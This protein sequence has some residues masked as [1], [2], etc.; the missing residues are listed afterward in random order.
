MI[1]CKK[2]Y[3]QKI[4]KMVFPGIQGGPLMH[5]I[6]AKAV[7][8]GEAMT[9]EF[10]DYQ[11]RIVANAARL[12]GELTERGFRLVTG[13]TNTHLMLV[14][15]TNKGLTGK[16]AADTLDEAGI[17]VNMNTI[18]FDKKGPA[19]TSGIRPGT[20]SVTTCGMGEEEMVLIAEL[21]D[22]TLEARSDEARLAEIRERVRELCERFPVPGIS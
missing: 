7:C 4:D 1:L 14:D 20:P 17:T 19:V 22:E 18:P 8:L 13:G 5:V 12:A 2:K 3:A 16:E 10:A 21:I 15:V 11:R 9:D 6:A